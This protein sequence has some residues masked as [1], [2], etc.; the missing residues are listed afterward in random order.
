MNGRRVVK[1][2]VILL[3]T[4]TRGDVQPFIALGLALRALGVTAYLAS[5]P[6][7]AGLAEAYDLPFI[8]ME[9]NPSSLMTQGGRQALTLEGSLAGSLR[10]SLAY[11][12]AARPCYRRML[13]NGWLACQGATALVVGL[14]SLWGAH[15]AEAL[16]IPCVYGFQ[17]P[18]T[19][20]AAFP[21]ALLPPGLLPKGAVFNRLSHRLIEQAV[22]QPWRGL[23]NGWRRERMGLKSAPWLGI[24]D[25]MYAPD[26]LVIQ[27]LSSRV[28]PAPS[29]SPPQ[30]QTSGFWFLDPPPAW[31]PPAPLLQ[32]L[33]AGAPPVYIGFGSPGP[34]QAAAAAQMI[35]QTASLSGQR[36]VTGLA[37]QLFPPGS[38]AD[39][40][41]CAED[42]PHAWLFPRCAALVHHGGAGTTAAGLRAGRPTLVI[43]RATDQFFWGERVRALGC[44]PNPLAQRSLSAES[45]AERLAQMGEDSP[46]NHQA[47]QMGE[48]LRTET[49]AANAASLLLARL[50]RLG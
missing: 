47:H 3:T 34:Q 5:D 1:H 16:D 40:I 14:P 26:A 24:T 22:W 38:L 23:I 48:H 12:R 10:A 45:L 21:S 39:T 4:G 19:R 30:H 2:K 37:R 13:D 27:A 17:Q 42:V 6:A 20:T 32:F 43:P 35:L 41:F 44:G 7:F 18:F 8:E 9:G 28:V 11:L 50:P 49:G 15:I 25:R 33:D 46:Y 36:L 31:Q 29:D